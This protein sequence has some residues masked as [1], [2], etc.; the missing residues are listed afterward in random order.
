MRLVDDDGEVAVAH[1][2][3]GVADERE[4]LNGGRDDALA[5]LHRH[6]QFRAVV[7][8]LEYFVA[9]PEGFEVV[10]DLLVEHTAV[11]DDNHRGEQRRV[12]TGGT[13]RLH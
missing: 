6:F 11:G 13:H 8:V 7:G 10:G 12:E 5:L 4:F 1:V 2:G 9:L 3:N